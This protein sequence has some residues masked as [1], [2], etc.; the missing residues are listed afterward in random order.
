M[1]GK[2]EVLFRALGFH[3]ELCSFYASKRTGAVPGLGSMDARLE[4]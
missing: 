3:V 4:G 2:G 1:V